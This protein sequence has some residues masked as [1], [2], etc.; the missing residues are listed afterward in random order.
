[1]QRSAILFVLLCFSLT[2]AAQSID[3]THKRIQ[4]LAAERNYSAAAAELAKLKAAQ[5]IIFEANNYD[6]LAA[7]MSEKSGDTAAALAYYQSVIKRDSILREYALWH[8]SRIARA[9][10][11]L[12]LERIRLEELLAYS[13]DSLFAGAARQELAESWFAGGDVAR[14]AALFEQQISTAKNSAGQANSQSSRKNIAMLADAKLTL[15]ETAKARELYARL[16]AETLNP[17]QADDYALAGA[18]GLD[19]LDAAGA[20]RHELSDYEHLQRASIYQ[21]NRDFKNAQTHYEAILTKYPESG[22]AP[23]AIFQIGRGFAQRGDYVEAVQWF[24]RVLERYPDH[25]VAKDAL[26]QAASSYA[27]V[28]KEREAVS[29]YRRYIELYPDDPRVDRAYLNIVDILRDHREESEA[30]KWANEAKAVFR[31]KLPEALAQFAEARIYLSR[32]DWEKALDGLEK[33]KNLSELGGPSV[34]GGTTLAEVTFLRG[35]VLESL[36]RFPEAIDAYLSIPDGRNEY[37]G[38]RA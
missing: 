22:I 11:N 6:Y 31:G 33:L 38:W 13:P 20:G 2:V 4:D 17:G 5:P 9:S 1:M 8:V 35:F 37:Y 26:L 24:E 14:S 36:R 28:A 10:G 32:G 7:R 23:D 25:P 18:L 30:I 3:E 27:R 29:R 16:I 21:F 34:P 15:G 12:L 19:R